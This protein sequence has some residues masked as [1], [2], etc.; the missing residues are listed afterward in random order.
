[1]RFPV[2]C[3]PGSLGLAAFLLFVS[4]VLADPVETDH[5]TVRLIAE[6]DAV[7]PGET[8]NLALHF[9][10]EDEWHIYWKNPG[11]SGLAPEVEWDM[12]EGF[13]AGTIQWPTPQRIEMSGL[14]NYGY[15]G[16][17]TFIVPVH[18]P[19]SL[20]VGETQ[21][22]RAEATWLICKEICLPGDA[23]LSLELRV[24]ETAGPGPMAE[25]F[26]A[27]RASQPE[28]GSPWGLRAA[29]G[30][31]PA[32][33]IEIEAEDGPGIPEDIYFYAGDSEVTDPNIPQSLS[34]RGPE[35]AVLEAGLSGTFFDKDSRPDSVTGILASRDGSWSVGI[36]LVPAPEIAA[37]PGA[38]G[39]RVATT[40]GNG[41]E[42]ELLELGLPGW[43]GLAFLGGLILNVMPCV[44]PVLSI[45]VFSLF[46]HSGQSRG[47]AVAHGSA[48]TAGVVLSFAALAVVLF[49]LREAGERIGWGFQLQ[50]PG[51]VVALA[52]LFLLFGL[53][54]LGV[55]EIGGGLVG[56]DAKV[57]Q[58][59]D[60][61]GSLGT[62]VLAAVV[63]APCVGPFVGGVSGVALQAETATGIAVF[64]M[65][66]FGMASPFLVLSIFP[67]LAERL[68]KPGPWM[69]T[70]K[71]LMGFLLLA[72]VVFLAWVAG[73]SG[74]V[75]A[76]MALLM[77][78]LA[79]GVAAWVYG[80]WGAASRARV[81]RRIALVLA[82]GLVLGSGVWGGRSAAAAYES[83][84]AGAADEWDAWSK[85]R[86]AKE[87]SD[88]NPVFVDF[89]A[90]WCLICQANKKTALRT[91]AT[92]ELFEAKDIVALTADWTR[93]DAAITDELE[94]YGRSGVPLYLL[95]TPDGETRVLPQT[96]TH[97]IVREAVEKAL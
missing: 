87:L 59:R 82:V 15:E 17:A 18:V 75:P 88:G 42:S 72:A 76:M 93:Y 74:G 57:S 69:E 39:G 23:D 24:K 83:Y 81:T 25:L 21:T 43:L 38:G 35:T 30:E 85:E 47:E 73:A 44:L 28:Q 90:T 5:A 33:R 40:G 3:R 66:G 96:L 54:L 70:F 10:L 84:T 77:T 12:P 11:A 79:A 37:T 8:L 29:V 16:A 78:L 63:G 20:E 7:V 41:L 6:T 97:G 32:L 62:G 52:I 34:F 56:A 4:G 2:S 14:V 91:E 60:L 26:E 95:H 45:K 61:L 27:G 80:R 89:T 1:M 31:E 36:P 68:P 65:M 53:N 51:F 92:R 9:D 19:E 86:V 22:I 58:R 13:E 48:Y 94:R 50:N 64:G 46:K 49:A 55:F 67:K 71:H